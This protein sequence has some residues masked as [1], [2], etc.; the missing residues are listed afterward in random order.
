MPAKRGGARVE[1]AVD[2]QVSAGD[3]ALSEG[4]DAGAAMGEGQAHTLAACGVGEHAVVEAGIVQFDGQGLL[5]VDAAAH[6]LGGLT[7]RQAEQELRTQTV[8]G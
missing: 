6:R 4:F 7:V 5:E 1:S 8:A 3:D 2:N